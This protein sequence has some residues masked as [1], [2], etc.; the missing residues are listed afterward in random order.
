MAAFWIRFLVL[1][2]ATQF[3]AS[4]S[5]ERNLDG[6]P[7]LKFRSRNSFDYVKLCISQ[8]WKN[9]IPKLYVISKEKNYRY[10]RSIS[11]LKVRI[12][13]AGK[14]RIVEVWSRYPL[15]DNMKQ[16]ISDCATKKW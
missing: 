7:D 6:A 2:T 9:E 5:D 13:D 3:I 4:C 12:S 14:L 11:G 1:I 16:Y 8:D 10:Y 15:T